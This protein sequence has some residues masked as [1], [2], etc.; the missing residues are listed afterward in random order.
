[1]ASYLFVDGRYLDLAYNG[2]MDRFFGAGCGAV[3]DM[4]NVIRAASSART[5]YYHAVDD[6]PKPGETEADLK[7]RVDISL[8]RFDAINALPA[9]HV[10]LGTITGRALKKRRQKQVDVQLAVDAL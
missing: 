10:R 9:T 3:L 8:A 1:M 7:A 4:D 2:L 6:E 5:Y